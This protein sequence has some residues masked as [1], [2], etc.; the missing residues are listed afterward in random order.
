MNEDNTRNEDWIKYFSWDLP[1]TWDGFYQHF[2]ETTSN[3]RR[4]IENFM[5]LPAARKM[6]ED[7][8]FQAEI[9][10]GW[11]GGDDP[12]GGVRIV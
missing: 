8:R 6:P 12:V 3:P 7:L 10:L 1:T 9:Y 4:A 5:K 11:R 2:L